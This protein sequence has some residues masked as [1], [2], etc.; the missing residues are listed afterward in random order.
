M[1]IQAQIIGL[2]AD[3]QQRY[4]MSYLFISHDLRVVQA[5]AD[6]VAV[7]LRGRIVEHGPAAEVFVRPRHPYTQTL[8]AAAFSLGGRQTDRLS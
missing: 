1:T 3:L 6:E 2:L 4:Q 5:L 7:M 8:F